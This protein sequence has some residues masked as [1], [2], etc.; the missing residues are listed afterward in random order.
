MKHCQNVCIGGVGVVYLHL[1]IGEI[2]VCNFR[3]PPANPA[4]TFT[5]SGSQVLHSETFMVFGD[6]DH[7]FC[8]NHLRDIDEIL[9]LPLDDNKDGD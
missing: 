4:M 8:I 7:V 3:I 5:F 2:W 1:I 9:G 6:E